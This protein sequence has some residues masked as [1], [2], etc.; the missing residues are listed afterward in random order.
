MK[1]FILFIAIG[2]VLVAFLLFDETKHLTLQWILSG[3]YLISGVILA[4]LIAGNIIK[5]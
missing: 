1:F 5:F 2:F 3:L 4:F